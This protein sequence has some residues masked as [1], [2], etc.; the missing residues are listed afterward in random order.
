VSHDADPDAAKITYRMW[1]KVGM[2]QIISNWADDLPQI[3]VFGKEY[4]RDVKEFGMAFGYSQR[5]LRASAK[6]GRSLPAMKAEGCREFCERRIDDVAAYGVPEA[7][8]PGFLNHPNVPIATLPTGGWSGATAELILADLNYLVTQ[9]VVNTKQV[10]TPDTLLLPTDL[11]MLISQK[12][13]G[14][15]LDDTVLGI[16]LKTNPFIK[17][18]ETWVK[19]DTAA[20]DGGGRIVCYKRDSRV[21]ELEMVQEFQ[22]EAPQ[23]KGRG[24]SVDCTTRR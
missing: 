1:D 3:E 14:N 24:V 9:I 17:N 21:L 19:L 20:A 16:F 2:A 10:E 13:A 22:Q 6:V 8:I 7:D 4:S 23:T 11:F 5:E 15:Q 18:V 12:V